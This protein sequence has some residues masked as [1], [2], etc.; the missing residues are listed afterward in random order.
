MKIDEIIAKARRYLRDPPEG[1][2][3]TS[4]LYDLLVDVVSAKV[5]DLQLSDQNFFLRKSTFTAS[6]RDIEVSAEDFSVPVKL[7]RRSQGVPT[8]ELGTPIKIINYAAWETEGSGEVASVYGTPPRLALGHDPAGFTYEL[9]YEPSV[10]APQ[11]LQDEPQVATIFH[12]LLVEELALKALPLVKDFSDEWMSFR[13]MQAAMLNNSI[14]DLRD[15]WKKW[16]NLS[17]DQGV[18]YKRPYRPRG[19]RGDIWY[20]RT[21]AT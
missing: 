10:S 16:I 9:W 15:Q 5:I 11:A 2:L 1:E 18:V 17:R 4:T 8:T 7:V 19:S 14:R 20:R 12:N 21:H 13:P 3:D 6:T